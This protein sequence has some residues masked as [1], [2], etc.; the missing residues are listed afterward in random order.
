MNGELKTFDASTPIGDLIEALD[1]TWRHDELSDESAPP[2]ARAAEREV[3]RRESE[4]SQLRDLVDALLTRTA[5]IAAR[6]AE[7]AAVI[8]RGV[9]LMTTEQV[10]KWEGVRAWQEWASRSI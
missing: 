5:A 6:E 4:R 8:A 2:N 9:E 10:G 3:K 7:A 1:Y